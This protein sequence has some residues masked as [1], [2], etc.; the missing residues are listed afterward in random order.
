MAGPAKT[1]AAASTATKTRKAPAK[2]APARK[3][4]AKAPPVAPAKATGKKPISLALQG[5]GSH[6]AFAWGVLDRLFE[7]DV[8]DVKSIVGTSAGAMNAS[9]AAYGLARG[10]PEGAR[11]KLSEFWAAISDSAR[12][13]PLQPSW[14]DKMR[15]PGNMDFS[16]F[17][18][19]FDMMSRF[20][21]PYQL[22]P[23]NLNP[24]RDVLDEVIDFD[25]MHDETAVK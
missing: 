11:E 2:K 8:F 25:W 21:S 10:G 17:F 24:L 18:A 3:P 12:M 1:A 7:A 5:G 16:P 6:G 13:S 23:L 22:N 15:G 19:A 4:A 14:V 9:V 20:A